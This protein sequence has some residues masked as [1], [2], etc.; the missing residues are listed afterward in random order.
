MQDEPGMEGIQLEVIPCSIWCMF[1]QFSW[2]RLPSL[3]VHC[4]SLTLTTVLFILCT[5]CF[6]F[7]FNVSFLAFYGISFVGF[8]VCLIAVVTF[9]RSQMNQ[10]LHACFDLFR[11]YNHIS[12]L[13]WFAII[14]VKSELKLN[15]TIQCCT[16]TK[17]MTK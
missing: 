1:V 16:F 15:C 8:F 12:S 9:W 17:D 5:L 4:D 13:L 10:E 6:V 14:K 11:T 3:A 7:Q 2:F